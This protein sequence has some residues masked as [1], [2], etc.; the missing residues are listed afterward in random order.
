MPPVTRVIGL[1]EDCYE[2]QNSFDVQG[3]S[4]VELFQVSF[5]FHYI[6]SKRMTLC[7]RQV[8]QI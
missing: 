3:F 7:T 8:I 1:S 6:M 5:V 2:I 4:A